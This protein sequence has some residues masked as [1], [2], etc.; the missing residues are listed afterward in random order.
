METSGTATAIGTAI[1]SR[2]R[3]HR[4][5][6]GWTLD[7][8]AERSGVSRRMVINVEQ[9]ASN[10]SIA[11][12]LRLSDALGVGL[13]TLVDVERP[14]ALRV[15]AAGQAPVLWRGPAG[16]QGQLV[17]G[18]EPPDVV[19]LWD[20]TLAPGETYS[21]EAHSTGTRELLLVLAGQVGLTVGQQTQVLTVGESAQFS[22]DVT[23]GYANPAADGPTARFC[24]TVFEPNITGRAPR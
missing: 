20:W 13:P 18:T 12:L 1:G 22:G 23:H 14:G 16:G 19:E 4:V 3:D 21:T 7:Q 11:T 17:A 6:R 5:E 8:L 2:V 15:V 24:L 10:P 9:G